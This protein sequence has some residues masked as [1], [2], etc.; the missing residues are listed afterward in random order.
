MT[1]ALLVA[2]CSSGKQLLGKELGTDA[3]PATQT[4]SSYFARWPNGPSSSS[5]FVPLMVWL[6]S[7]E[8]AARYADAGINFYAGLY[9]GP[10]DDQLSNLAAASMPAVCDQSGVW[11]T[12]VT[13]STIQ[14]WLQVDQPDDAQLQS[15]GSYAPCID[16]GAIV[17]RYSGMVASDPTRP[18]FLNLG[19]GVA[20]PNWEGRG[21]CS[22]NSDQYFTYTEGADALTLVDYPVSDGRPLEAVADGVDALLRFSNREKF[23]LAAIQASAIDGKV[24]PTPAQ[25]KAEVWLALVH[26]AGGIEYYCHQIEPTVNE[27]ACIDDETTRAALRDLNAQ[28]TSLAPVLNSPTIAGGVTVTAST[29]VDTLVKRAG[30][31]TYVFAVAH[32][33]S[34]TSAHFDL[35]DLDAAAT[36]EVLGEQRTLNVTAGT[37]DDAFAGYAVHLYRVTR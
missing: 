8:N 6:Q 9:E 28:I 26:G 4:G 30:N 13:D 14:G 27:T 18:V 25:I 12:H 19:R 35:P 22:G 3:S 23:V 20:E 31:A 34:T 15:D 10:T 5:S 7:P 37:F 21:A 11:R 33:G 36:A 16:P 32:G 2:G 29:T 24:T 1:A 17:K